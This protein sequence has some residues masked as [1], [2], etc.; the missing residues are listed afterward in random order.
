[1]KL[2]SGKHGKCILY[3]KT[4]LMFFTSI[5]YSSQLPWSLKEQLQGWKITHIC[6]GGWLLLTRCCVFVQLQV[7]LVCMEIFSELWLPLQVMVKNSFKRGEEKLRQQNGT[8]PT[9]L[10]R[11]A[12]SDKW[13]QHLFY[14][15]R[16]IRLDFPLWVST[17]IN[18]SVLDKMYG[19]LLQLTVYPQTLWPSWRSW[20]T[21]FVW[22]L[23]PPVRLSRSRHCRWGA[24]RRNAGLTHSSV[25]KKTIEIMCNTTAMWPQ[26]AGLL[27][28]TCTETQ[29]RVN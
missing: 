12:G 21:V 8:T 18:E 1:M 5:C 29:R 27:P 13:R 6:G 2:P 19:V 16:K 28:L 25:G 24:R 9:K 17:K 23:S 15:F 14:F 22:V 26:S 20:G 11:K 3:I 7:T 4:A 10:D